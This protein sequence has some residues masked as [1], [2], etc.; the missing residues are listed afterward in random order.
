MKCVT[1]DEGCMILHDIHIGICGS[2]A[3]LGLSWERHTG[4]GSF[5]LLLCLTPTPWSI[6]VKVASFSLARN[7]CH[8]IN[9]R[10]YLLPSLFHM[11]AGF[12]I[13]TRVALSFGV[14]G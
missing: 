14:R 1:P 13:C 2:H 10:P 11:G 5:G 8:L 4:K 6:G 9:Y 12:V 3:G 7:M